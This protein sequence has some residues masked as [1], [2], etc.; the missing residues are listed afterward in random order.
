VVW[1]DRKAFL[2]LLDSGFDQQAV[3]TSYRDAITRN[4]Q[5]LVDLL[6]YASALQ[7][8]H[9]LS[10]TDLNSYWQS[11]QPFFAQLNLPSPP[12]AWEPI[13]VALPPL[14]P[15]DRLHDFTLTSIRRILQ[16]FRWVV[17]RLRAAGSSC[18]RSHD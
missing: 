16:R 8:A 11:R 18:L 14:T 13:S 3:V 17:H 15:L 4:P 6:S 9:P 5:A 10:A 2:Q 12:E 7:Q 1:S